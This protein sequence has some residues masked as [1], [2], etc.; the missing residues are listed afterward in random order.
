MWSEEGKAPRMVPE[1]SLEQ[2]LDIGA[3]N[4][5]AVGDPGMDQGVEMV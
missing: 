3:L 5:D 4:Q 2:W 1:S